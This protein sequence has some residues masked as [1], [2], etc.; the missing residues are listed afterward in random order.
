MIVKAM[1][2]VGNEVI[3]VEEAEEASEPGWKWSRA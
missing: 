3:T 1:Q 2:K